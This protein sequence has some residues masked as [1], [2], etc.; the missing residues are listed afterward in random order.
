M[1]ERDRLVWNPERQG[2]DLLPMAQVPG[3]RCESPVEVMFFNAAFL[4]PTFRGL[5]KQH[6]I[7]RFEV[8]FALPKER[9]VIEIDGHQWHSTKPQR[10]KDL[11]RQRWL[12]AQGWTVIRF[13]GSEIYKSAD[14]C[15]T[16]T[17][18]ILHRRARRATQ[19][20][21]AIL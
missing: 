11:Q 17:K 21:K 9:I 1:I 20:K 5:K 3:P 6:K 12:Q 15:V 13:T 16:E 2:F 18:K 7:G 19:P 14:A 4:D 10:Q 8:D